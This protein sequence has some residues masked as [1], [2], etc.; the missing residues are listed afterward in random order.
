MDPSS[1]RKLS[2]KDIAALSEE[3]RRLCGD[4]LDVGIGLHDLLDAREG[5]LVQLVVVGFG[6]EVVD[7]L[8]PVGG[9]D[10]AVVAYKALVY[11]FFP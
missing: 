10:V 3:D 9:Q 8:L 11:L 1:H 6:L 2:D 5:Q 7:S 4:H